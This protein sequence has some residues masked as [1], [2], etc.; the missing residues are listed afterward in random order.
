MQKR[1]LGRGLQALLGGNDEPAEAIGSADVMASE[2]GTITVAQIDRNPYQPRREFPADELKSL[3][4]SIAVHGVIQP[5]VVRHVGERYQLIAGERRLRAAEMLGLQSI[6]ARIL[7][8]T[9]Q[10]VFEIALVENLQRQDLNAIEKAAAFADYVERYQATHEQLAQQL[11]SIVPPSPTSFA[12]WN[13]PKV[14]A[15]RFAM[16]RFR[17][18]TRGPCWRLMT[19]L[20]KLNCVARSS[21]Q[22]CRSVRSSSWFAIRNPPR[23]MLPNVPSQPSRIICYRLN[24]NFGSGSALKFS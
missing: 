8:L 13:C 21:T 10:Q 19:R 16:A 9:E 3:A 22:A 11:A 15:K 17:T 23:K 20:G 1:K 18:V 24:P 6:P 14:S 4:D 7:E 12:C 2:L 5:I